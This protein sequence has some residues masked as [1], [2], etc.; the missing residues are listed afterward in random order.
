MLGLKM[1]RVPHAAPQSLRQ[2]HSLPAWRSSAS[3]AVLGSAARSTTRSLMLIAESPAM[4]GV[5]GQLELARGIRIRVRIRGG[6]NTKKKKKQKKKAKELQY[7]AEREAVAKAVL[8]HHQTEMLSRTPASTLVSMQLQRA[9]QL[10]SRRPQR[11]D[12]R[13]RASLLNATDQTSDRQKL[14]TEDAMIWPGRTHLAADTAAMAEGERITVCGWVDR[15][16]NHG[17]V[18]FFDVRDSS[19]LVQAT[20][21]SERHPE[22]AAAA[23]RL[24]IEYVVAATGILRKRKDPNPNIPTG[25]VEVDVEHVTVINAVTTKLQL[26]VSEAASAKAQGGALKED[27][28]LENRVLD[29]RRIEMVGNLR[30]RHQVVRSMRRFLEDQEGFLE[31]ETPLLTRSTPEGARDFLV[32]SRVQPGSWYA[33]P[34][35]PQLFKQMLMVGGV[36]RYF[37][38]ARCFRDED[39]RSDRQPEF[40]QLDMEMAFMDQ[41]SIMALTERLMAAIFKEVKGQQLSLPLPTMTYKEAMARYGCDKPDTRYGLELSDVSDAVAGCSF[42]PFADVEKG[43]GIIK[44]LRVPDGKRLSNTAVKPKGE[45]AVEA[46][47]GGG[48]PLI[49]M[50][51]KDLNTIDGVTPVRQ[52]F[53]DGQVAALIAALDAQPGDLLLL[54]GGKEAAVNSALDKVRQKVAAVLKMVPKD[55]TAL[56]WITDFP[57]FEWN[58]GEERLEAIHHPFTAPHPDD[59]ADLRTARALAYDLVLNGTEIG[60]G[61]LRIYKRA[62]QQRVFKAIGLGEEEAVAKFGAL[63][64]CLETGAPPH[65]GI[66]FGLDRLVMLL[67]GATSIRDVIAFPKTTTAQCLLMKAPSDVSDA[68]LADLHVARAGKALEPPPPPFKPHAHHH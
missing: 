61:S 51:V 2:A 53:D 8:E 36:D 43:G 52:G 46:A 56:L 34:Q 55:A 50:R 35:S 38:I 5:L 27:L 57:M 23:E 47:A 25:Q 58:E 17:G 3:S 12:P 29:L 11:P 14:G 19:G 21:A 54:I 7:R 32:P 49:Y 10:A 22:A 20:V 33:L 28:R 62:V 48:G 45:I 16:R 31:V 41:P 4:T 30:L 1:V 37:Q 59:V 15:Y 40:T 9:S 60:G 66:A 39:L 44:G 18:L 64:G 13:L 67:A 26:P 63:L 24:R 6:M 65:G 42:K 68:Q